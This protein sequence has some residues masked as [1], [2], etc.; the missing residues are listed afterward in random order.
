[1]SFQKIRSEHRKH[2]RGH[3]ELFTEAKEL[4]LK[5]EIGSQK[6]LPCEETYV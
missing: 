5:V 2:R 4:K 1:M 6:K 3:A